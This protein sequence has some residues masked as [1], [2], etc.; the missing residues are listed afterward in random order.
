MQLPINTLTLLAAS[1][2]I[3]TSTA[4]PTDPTC[5]VGATWP[6]HHD[7]HRFYECAAGGTPVRKTCGPHTAYSAE[8]GVCDYEW[9]VSTCRR[10]YGKKKHGAEGG[11][12]EGEKKEG[13]KKEYRV[14]GV[15]MKEGEEKEDE[16][17]GEK[18]ED[19]KKKERYR[20]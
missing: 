1:L 7:C 6:D 16:R 20:E 4:A 2:L 18:K 5:H 15:E 8:L 17:K 13:E 14:E 19:V 9:R 12:R 11:M 10:G 3:A